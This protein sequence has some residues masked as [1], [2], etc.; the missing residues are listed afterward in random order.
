MVWR[1][2]VR[3]DLAVDNNKHV[4]ELLW[5][6]SKA[7][8]RAQR[9]KLIELATDLGYPTN[10]LRLSLHSY[11]WKRSLVDGALISD[12]IFPTIG[13]GAGSAF[14]TYELVAYVIADLRSIQTNHPQAAI[15]LHVDDLTLQITGEGIQNTVDNTMAMADEVIDRFENNLGLPFDPKKAQLTSTSKEV[16]KIVPPGR[17]N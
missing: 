3:G 2:L 5:D 15:S 11:T 12:P 16:A 8:E 4:V 9:Q 17:N 14:A 1:N 7:F 10:Q 13:I 6:V